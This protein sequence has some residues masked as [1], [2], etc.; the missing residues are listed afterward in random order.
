MAQSAGVWICNAGR[1]RNADD[2]C[3]GDLW[4]LSF[5][6]FSMPVYTTLMPLLTRAALGDSDFEGAY[7]KVT[8]ASSLTASL[9]TTGHG[10]LYDVTGSY[11]CSVSLCIAAM[12]MGC[13]LMLLLFWKT[14]KNVA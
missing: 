1:N 6:C 2:E 3:S 12:G 14:K 11:T 7:P 8:M 10:W 4:S 13:I 9:M 5:V